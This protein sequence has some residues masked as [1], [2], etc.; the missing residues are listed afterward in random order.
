MIESRGNARIKKLQKLKKSARY[1]RQEGLFVIEGWKMTEE[2]LRR[3]L[4]QTLYIST[5]VENEYKEKLSVP[6]T[7]EVEILSG[8]L[9]RELSDTI[10]PQGVMAAVSMPR[11]EKEPLYQKKDAALL[12][13]EDIQDPGNLGTMIRTAEGAGMTG[14]VLSGGCVDIFNPK[15]IRATMGSL[16]RVPFWYCDDLST[17]VELLKKNH[18]TI[19]AAHLEGKSAYTGE[20]YSGKVGLL[21][22]NEAGGLSREISEKADKKIRIPMAGEVESLNA[23]VSAALLMYE[24]YRNRG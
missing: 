24:V 12:C 22:G 4:V 1:R 17:E 15:V 16:L 13:L 8:G 7:T 2:A 11:Y 9:F 20:S 5:D 6:E 10:T 14:I 21:I 23:A 18:F 19:Y 3:G